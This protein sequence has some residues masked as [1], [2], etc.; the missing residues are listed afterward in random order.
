MAAPIQASSDKQDLKGK[1]ISVGA[2]AGWPNDVKQAFNFELNREKTKYCRAVCKLCNKFAQQIS[3]K[4]TGRLVN[5]VIQYGQNGTVHLLL[6]NLKRHLTSNCHTKA[7]DLNKTPFV[8]EDQQT[9]KVNCG[10]TSEIAIANCKNLINIAWHIAENERPFTDF[11]KLGSLIS[12]CGVN[13]TG[14]YLSS[15]MCGAFVHLL[16]REIIN[17]VIEQV[18]SANFVSFLVDGST[19][20]KKKLSHEGELMYIRT[21]GDL[22]PKVE[23]FDFISMKNYVSVNADNL[24]H[25]VKVSL[26]A[27]FS[28]DPSLWKLCDC[29]DQ[30]ECTKP[31]SDLVPSD[32][33]DEALQKFN[34]KIIGGSADGAA[35]NFGSR[36]GLMTQLQNQIPW[37]IAIH[38]LRL[39]FKIRILIII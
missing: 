20:Y 21:A 22:I 8:G 26:L 27:L 16:A 10:K 18:S 23:L 2:F 38:C 25:A 3:A 15:N 17:G 31:S 4:Y 5:D 9:L 28:D 1:A 13:I 39:I 34:K 14:S 11:A 29:S 12:E 24:T 33:L 30:C 6:P 7:L 37:F 32:K 19:V 35:V 36:K